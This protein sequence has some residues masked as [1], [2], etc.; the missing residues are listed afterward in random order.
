MESERSPAPLQR[1][2]GR[3]SSGKVV[4][5]EKYRAKM[6]E[7]AKPCFRGT[8]LEHAFMDTDF[9]R[10]LGLSRSTYV[11]LFRVAVHLVDNQPNTKLTGPA[12]TEN[13]SEH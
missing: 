4:D 11:D 1:L 5:L 10:S 12:P 7:I 3:M 8:P 9:Y 13:P 6:M 2:V